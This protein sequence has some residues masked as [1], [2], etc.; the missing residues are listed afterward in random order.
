MPAIAYGSEPFRI[1]SVLAAVAA[2]WSLGLPP[3]LIRAGIE[4][5]EPLRTTEP[6]EAEAAVA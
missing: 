5:F 1:E 2:A 6:A 4:G 3:E